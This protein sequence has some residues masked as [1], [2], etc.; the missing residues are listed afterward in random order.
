M[1]GRA[2]FLAAI[3][4]L[5]AGPCHAQTAADAAAGEEQFKKACGVCHTV[6]SNAPVRQGPNLHG[7]YGRPSGQMAGFKYSDAL[8]AAKLTWDD[9][10]LDRWLTN[11]AALVPGTIMAYR[12]RDPKSA[13]RSS[14]I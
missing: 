8:V 10:T 14:P 3:G 11:P 7:V 2:G 5:L 6:E 12:Q 4:V 9:A 1:A 13:R